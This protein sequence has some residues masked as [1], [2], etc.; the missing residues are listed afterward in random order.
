[1][2]LTFR[3]D[4]GTPWNHLGSTRLRIRSM[5][6]G[7]HWPRGVDRSSLSGGVGKGQLVG[8]FWPGGSG[9]NKGEHLLYQDEVF[10]VG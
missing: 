10:D 7:L 9:E 4:L 5:V 3:G 8:F 6:S 2:D 1:M